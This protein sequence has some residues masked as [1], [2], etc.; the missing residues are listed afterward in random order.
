VAFCLKENDCR[1]LSQIVNYLSLWENVNKNKIVINIIVLFA[2]ISYICYELNRLKKSAFKQLKNMIRQVI[3]FILFLCFN[4]CVFCQVDQIVKMEKIKTEFHCPT[5]KM[6]VEQALIKT[7]G[8]INVNADLDSKIVTIKYVEGK[9]NRE[10]L[11]KVI[12]KIGFSTEDSKK[13]NTITI[14]YKQDCKK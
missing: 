13:E 5:G 6:L 8:V 10:N 1:T 3:F 7:D 9:T 4:S 11:V 2:K 12:E 14:T